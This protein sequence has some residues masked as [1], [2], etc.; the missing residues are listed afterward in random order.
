MNILTQLA[1]LKG[2]G[3]GATISQAGETADGRPVKVSFGFASPKDY[4]DGGIVEAIRKTPAVVMKATV[5]TSSDKDDK[6]KL[7]EKKVFKGADIVGVVAG[8]FGIDIALHPA[9]GQTL[10]AGAGT[11]VAVNV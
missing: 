11:Q 5:N 3:K 9:D 6:R 4:S 2:A 7:T 8:A 1:G 10:T